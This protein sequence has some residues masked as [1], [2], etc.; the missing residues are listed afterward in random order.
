MYV[1]GSG[2]GDDDNNNKNNKDNRDFMLVI[3]KCTLPHNEND[4]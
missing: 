4:T 3:L 2:G 1:S